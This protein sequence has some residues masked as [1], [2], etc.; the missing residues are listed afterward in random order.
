MKNPGDT[1]KNHQQILR[2]TDTP[3]TGPNARVWV[4]KCLRPGC[5]HF[6]GSNG[7]DAFERRCPKCDHGAPGLPIPI[8]RDGERWTREE[9]II[10][11]QL[12]SRIPFG[13]IHMGNP[14]VNELAALLGRKVGSASLKLANFARLDPV[15]IAR[16]VTGMTSGSK[17][18]A[19]VWQEFEDRPEALAYESAQILANHLG[20]TVEKLVDVSESELPPP[21]TEREAL[22]KLRVNQ[23]FFRQRVLSAYDHRCC[24]TGLTNPNLLVASHIIPWAEN[25]THR[26]DPRNGLCLNALHDRAFDRHLMWVESDLVVRLSPS[27]RQATDASKA[28]VDW[29]FSFD[30][31]QLLLPK[32]FQPD[33]SFLAKHADRC[34]DLAS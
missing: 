21:G 18:E 7:H 27:L 4:L 3:G 6:Y 24:V 28:T 25:A 13:S 5:S 9:H 12:Y 8:E 1:N 23:S 14:L 29:L 26:L 32:H 16:G 34:Q 11:F 33:A 30:G 19:E 31:Q 2:L 20:C 17:G 22:V 15:H 10:A